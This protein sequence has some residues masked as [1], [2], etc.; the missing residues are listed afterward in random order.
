MKQKLLV[1]SMDATVHEDV[2]Y[3]ETLP[4]FQKILGKRAEVERVKSVFPAITYP[5]HSTLM[6]GCTPGKHGIYNNEPFKTVDNGYKHWYLDS[7]WIRVEDLFAAAKRAGCTTASV[8]WPITGNNPNVDYIINEYFFL[9]PGDT[10]VEAAFKRMGANEEA[11][12][13]VRENMHRIHR[14]PRWP[15]LVPDSNFDDFLMGCACSLIRNVQPDVML[16]HNSFPDSCRHRYGVFGKEV[17]I[18]LDAIDMWLGNVIEALEE[19]GVYEQTNFVLLSDHGQMDL[20]RRVKINALLARGGFVDVA[21][22]GSLYGW[23]AFGQTNAM[24]SSIYL[25]DPA[26]KKLYDEVYAYL[27]K[28][29][30]EKVWGF[31]KVYTTEEAKEKYGTYGPFSFMLATDG[32][33]AVSEDWNEPPLAEVDLEDYTLARATHGYEPELGPQPIFLAH[34]PAF[35]D[36]AV[37]PTANLIDIAPTLAKVLG[38]EMPQADGRCLTELLK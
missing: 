20:K 27:Q 9:Q 37:L 38:Q 30:E 1:I 19:A 13:A 7:K 26:N 35:K 5:A 22:D 33:T 6:T 32:A 16:V 29:V 14:S 21:V 18:A 8:Y 24:S 23:R 25:L 11:L 3:L 36:G 4:N 28:I 10:D 17:K 15:V 12:K 31:T 2:A 34:G